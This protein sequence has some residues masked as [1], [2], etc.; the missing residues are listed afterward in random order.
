RQGL[1]NRGG[2]VAATQVEM[3]A[4][5]ARFRLGNR[6]EVECQA[7]RS[8]QRGITLS[9]HLHRAA[10]PATPPAPP[11]PP[12]AAGED[13]CGGAHDRRCLLAHAVLLFLIE[14]SPALDT[15]RPP[16]GHHRV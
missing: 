8:L 15:S 9:M 1:R 12:V 11:A 13:E 3:Q 2:E 10:E 4:I 7:L 6:E 16:Q 5:L 14:R